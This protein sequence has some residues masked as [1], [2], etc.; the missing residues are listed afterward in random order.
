M[1]PAARRPA[2]TPETALTYARALARPRRVGSGEDERVARDLAGRLEQFGYAVERQP[3]HFSTAANGFIA[4]EIGAGLLLIVAALWTRMF[5]PWLAAIPA[6]GL[7]ALLVSAEWLTRAARDGAL[8]PEAASPRL[9]IWP[10]LGRRF[11]AAN[12]VASLPGQPNHASRPHLY[13][14]AHYDSKSQAIPI[15]VRIILFIIVMSGSVLFVGLT[16][17]GLFFRALAPAATAAGLAALLTGLPLAALFLAEAGNASPGA[18]DNASGVGT[19]LHLAECL[20]ARPSN[21][22]RVTILLTSAEE[23]G[24][25]GAAA[26]VRQHAAHLR[27]QAGAG[28]LYV[29]NFDGV[30]AE[31]RLYYTG[32]P[33]RLSHLVEAASRE[34]G[35]PVRKFSLPGVLFDHM[36]F[37]QHGLEAVS[38]LSIG[39]ASWAVHTP[40]D[41]ADK[42]HL[43]GFERA[44]RVAL[45]V[46]E[47]L[48]SRGTAGTP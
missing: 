33:G 14:V 28:G 12:L 13:L 16:L 46:I 38:L 41:M 5:T 19:V 27:E 9:G 37:A 45:N 44:G 1:T 4:L 20:A 11:T 32:A 10:R 40:G 15:A 26:Y 3:F 24:L 39:R 29:L 48:A 31:G 18:I 42:L 34:L 21:G 23:L 43:E 22:L 36:P 6:A 8:A 35:V 25:M 30:G 2:F 7:L 17:A 47:K